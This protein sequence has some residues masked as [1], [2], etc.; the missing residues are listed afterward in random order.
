[1]PPLKQSG[2]SYTIKAVRRKLLIILAKRSILDVWQGFGYASERD[3]NKRHRKPAPHD[4]LHKIVTEVFS[5]EMT[6][7]YLNL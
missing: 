6:T 4:R 7:F 3:Q 2:E 5:L 1:M